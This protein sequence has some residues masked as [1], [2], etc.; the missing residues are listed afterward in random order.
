[1]PTISTLPSL[2]DAIRNM[3]EREYIARAFKSDNSPIHTLPFEQWC[4]YAACLSAQAYG[5]RLETVVRKATG[6]E[7][8]HTS[9]ECGDGRATGEVTGGVEIKCS[10]VTDSNP[11]LNMVQIRTWQ[12]MDKFAAVAIDVRNDDDIFIHAYSL[13]REEMKREEKKAWQRGAR[14]TK[15]EQKQQ[16]NRDAHRAEYPKTR[17]ARGRP[18]WNHHRTGQQ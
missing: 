10:L 4:R 16:E 3:R 8:L 14:N 18:E 12:G 7:R 2:A 5:P 11:R 13:T 6:L 15:G 17:G 9:E 1:M